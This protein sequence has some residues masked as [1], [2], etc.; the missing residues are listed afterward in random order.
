MIDR[1]MVQDVGQSAGDG[2]N[3]LCTASTLTPVPGTFLSF[4][5]IVVTARDSDIPYLV[6]AGFY[7]A[8][9]WVNHGCAVWKPAPTMCTS[10]KIHAA[11][12]NFNN[13]S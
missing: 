10:Q 7:T 6:G 3:A 11:E 1:Q 12:L 4:R 13:E 9:T 2:R 8:R 5:G